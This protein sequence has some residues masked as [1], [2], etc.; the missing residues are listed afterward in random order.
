MKARAIFVATWLCL[1]A[2]YFGTAFKPLGQ[3]VSFTDGH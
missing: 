1:F 2:F 3:I